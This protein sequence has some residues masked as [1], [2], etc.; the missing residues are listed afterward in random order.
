MILSNNLYNQANYMIKE[1]YKTSS[2]YL[3][4]SEVEL[5]CKTQEEQ[6]NN[7]RK[8]KKRN[9]LNKFLKHLTKFGNHSLNPLK[10]IR[11][12]R[13]NTKVVQSFQDIK[14]K[15]LIIL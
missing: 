7:Y 10:I 6:F 11:K 8:I 12:A 14:R 15:V 5:K 2:K 4:Y 9:V 13:L 3:S 1:H